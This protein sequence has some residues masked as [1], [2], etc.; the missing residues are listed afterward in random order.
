MYSLEIAR[1]WRDL[2]RFY[3]PSVYFSLFP[4]SLT[5]S[6]FFFSLSFF[7][8]SLLFCFHHLYL[9]PFSIEYVPKPNLYP[10][11]VLPLLYPSQGYIFLFL[12]ILSTPSRPLQHYTPPGFPV[13]LIHHNLS[14]FFFLWTSL[15]WNTLYSWSFSDSHYSLLSFAISLTHSFITSF[16]SHLLLN[17]LFHLIPYI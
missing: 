16:L 14:S 8:I 1:L 17:F 4:S 15:F 11:L 3:F 10:S 6:F 9:L 12:R 2:F 5:L 7:F 13:F